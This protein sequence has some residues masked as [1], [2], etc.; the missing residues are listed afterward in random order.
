MFKNRHIIRFCISILIIVLGIS[1]YEMI[2][3]YEEYI[4]SP[5]NV[6]L[7]M[8]DILYSK[9]QI[10]ETWWTII[11]G[12]DDIYRFESSFHV[13]L[14]P[15]DYKKHYLIVSAGR[16]LERIIYRRK[17]KIIYHNRT[18]F[19]GEETYASQINKHVYFIYQIPPISVLDIESYI[20][21]GG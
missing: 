10:E 20:D 13:N 2:D 16:P 6:P 1:I 4:A 12:P 9:D 5:I 19:F 15:N 21:V 8:I 14:P 3:K 7:S 18:N 17:S 11:Q